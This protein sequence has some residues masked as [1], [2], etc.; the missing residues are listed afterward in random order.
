MKKIVYVLFIVTMCLSLCACTQQINNELSNHSVVS[1]S[2]EN[3]IVSGD[4]LREFGMISGFESWYALQHNENYDGK[5]QPF[6]TVVT[7]DY[8]WWITGFDPSH[9]NA[10]ANNLQSTVMID[11]SNNADMGQA[12]KEAWGNV[13]S[14]DD[15]KATLVW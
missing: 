11:F 7:I 5:Y 8:Q 10:Q 14:F 9:Q 6:K 3:D 13:W 12:F 15:M 2:N 1:N 4:D